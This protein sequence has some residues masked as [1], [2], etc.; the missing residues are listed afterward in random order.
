M[1]V[2]A[3][4]SCPSRVFGSRHSPVAST[5]PGLVLQP[6]WRVSPL[7]AAQTEFV[8]QIAF[9]APFW[10]ATKLIDILSRLGDAGRV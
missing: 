4:Q 8:I 6:T 3:R 2:P 7:P 1:A 5:E 9:R 10:V